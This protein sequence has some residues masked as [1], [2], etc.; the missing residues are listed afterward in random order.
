MIFD[1]FPL[2]I[3]LSNFS[4]LISDFFPQS[5]AFS[6]L[7]IFLPCIDYYGIAVL[8]EPADVFMSTTS[9]N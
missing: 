5:A 8:K 7:I 1:F 4:F 6:F 2:R 3:Q 9:V